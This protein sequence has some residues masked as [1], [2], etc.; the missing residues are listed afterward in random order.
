MIGLADRGRLVL[1]RDL[2]QGAVVRD[3]RIVD[4]LAALAE[5]PAIVH[6]AEASAGFVDL[7]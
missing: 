3:G 2:V 4:V 5:L 1:D 7:K 6:E